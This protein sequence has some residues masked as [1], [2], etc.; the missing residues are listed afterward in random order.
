MPFRARFIPKNPDK[1]VGDVAKIFARSSWE[2]RVMQFFDSSSAVLTWKSEETVIPYLSPVDARIHEYW[3]DFVL[4]YKDKEGVVKTEIVEVKPRHESDEKYA[5][6][7]RSK[8]AVI[9]NEAKWKAA[10]LY[11]ESRGMTFRVLT[12]KSIFYQG[13]ISELKEAKALKKSKKKIEH[14]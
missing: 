14:G 11:C 9:I 8:E 12:E 6:S 2:L 13:K 4:T 5:K 10:I 3:P 7:D 1:Y